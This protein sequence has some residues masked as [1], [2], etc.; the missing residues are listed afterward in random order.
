MQIVHTW[1]RVHHSYLSEEEQNKL[2]L[3]A[4]KGDI[5][6]RNRVVEANLP[7]V[8]KMQHN[9]DCFQ[10]GVF[11]LIRAV[12]KFKPELGF[13][14]S[15]YAYTWIRQKIGR[16]ISDNYY[17]I[18]IPAYI[19]GIRSRYAKIKRELPD[20]EEK[21][22]LH[23]LAKET[24]YK[25]QDLKEKINRKHNFTSIHD[26]FDNSDE[27]IH[28]IVGEES[29]FFTT[30]LHELFKFLDERSL[31]ILRERLRGSSL[32]EVGLELGLSRERVRQLRDVALQRLRVL[33][34]QKKYYPGYGVLT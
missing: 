32:K 17:L 9:P 3:K 28:Q 6:A 24:G 8:F 11:G 19:N 14:F 7:M 16:Y 26:T 20:K 27:P 29:E 13:K 1:L 2:I 25:I 34:R 21:V 12:E 5:E 33:V 10:E 30:D 4:Q 18:R 23:K 31:F 15:T 22:I